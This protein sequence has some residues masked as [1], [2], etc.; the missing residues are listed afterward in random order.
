MACGQ[1][2][3][4]A[5]LLASVFSSVASSESWG[6]QDGKSASELHGCSIQGDGKTQAVAPAL[7]LLYRA[8]HPE[9]KSQHYHLLTVHW[10]GDVISL[11]PKEGPPKM[12]AATAA[13]VMYVSLLLRHRLMG[14]GTLQAAA[15]HLRGWL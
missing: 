13:A 5:G 9:F 3:G 2:H 8:G 10:L 15:C 12:P 4:S 1:G 7:V 6:I 11:S 14:A